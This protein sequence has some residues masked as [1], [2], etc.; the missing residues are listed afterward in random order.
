MFTVG[1][2]Y[3]FTMWVTGPSGGGHQAWTGRVIEVSG[4]LVKFR[5][6]EGAEAIVNTH[7]V[8]FIGAKVAEQ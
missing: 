5:D 8:A 4:P 3:E 2:S 7:S 1:K 6:T